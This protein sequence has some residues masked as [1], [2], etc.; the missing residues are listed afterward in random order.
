MIKRLAD[1]RSQ[2]RENVRGGTGVIKN[3]HLLE[4]S[5]TGGLCSL[6]SLLILEPGSSIG[7]HAHETDAEIFYILEGQ[8]TALE[9]GSQVVLNP[10]DCTFTSGGEVHGICNKGDISV[11]LLAVIIK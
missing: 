11:K 2:V 10:G 8:L 7:A 4:E 5:E 3:L 6:C 9:N 1:Q